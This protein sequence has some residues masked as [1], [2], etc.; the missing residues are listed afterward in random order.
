MEIITSYGSIDYDEL[1][2]FDLSSKT[3]EYINRQ[4][5]AADIF[6]A[7]EI[8]L[9]DTENDFVDEVQELAEVAIAENKFSEPSKAFAIAE[10]QNVPLTDIEEVSYSDSNFEVGGAEFVVYTEEEADEAAL[11]YAKN[12]IEDIGIEGLSEYAQ[13]YVYENFVNTKWFDEAMNEFNTSYA[14][15]IKGES[16]SDADTYIN[17]LHE[18]MVENGVMEDPEWPDE[19][20]FDNEDEYDVAKSDYETDL[21]DDVENKI[22]NFIESLN[23][24]YENG[25]EYWKQNFGDEDISRI[26]KENNLINED[27]VAEWLV[28]EDGRGSLLSGY[29]GEEDYIKIT[30]RGDSYEYYIYR[31]G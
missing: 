12:L 24:N 25:L 30:F 14:Y 11:E 5:A 13:T 9:I 28:E 19:D 20:D 23:D 17:R 8:D 15:D 31:V 7:K 16:A 21:E 6:F 18:E 4:K 27:D 2:D 26:A 29:D 3:M 10:N 22:E 1:E